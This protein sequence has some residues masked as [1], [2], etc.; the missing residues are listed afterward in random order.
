MPH[1]QCRDGLPAH[2]GIAENQ[3]QR[4]IPGPLP[5]P[6]RPDQRVYEGG[7][8]GTWVGASRR[9]GGRSRRATGLAGSTCRLTSQAQK[10]DTADWRMRIV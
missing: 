10:L 8:R 2:A 6:G 9:C 5:L 1:L 3:E 4:G 7:S